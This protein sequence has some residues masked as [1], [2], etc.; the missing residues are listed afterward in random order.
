MI[1]MKQNLKKAYRQSHQPYTFSLFLLLTVWT[2]FSAVWSNRAYQDSWILEG[3]FVPLLLTVVC[4]IGV[5]LT[6]SSIQAV[7]VATMTLTF[8]FFAL[9]S[10]KYVTPYGSAIDV[11][12]HM[13]LVRHIVETGQ[14]DPSN[15]YQYTAG[16]H[17]LPAIL[18]KLSGLDPER[19]VKVVPPFLGSLV[20]AIYYLVLNRI[21]APS[22]L[23][24][25]IIVLSG[26][27]LPLLYSLNGTTFTTPLYIFFLFL[28]LLRHF[29]SPW[30]GRNTFALTILILLVG[31][32][33]IIWHPSSSL[34]VIFIMAVGGLVTRVL[35]SSNDKGEALWRIGLLI[36]VGT[37][38]YWIFKAD[39]VWEH[40]VK[41]LFL[42]L[43]PELTPDLVPKR[44][45]ELSLVEQVQIGLYS[46]ARDVLFIA[47]AAVGFL[48]QMRSRI[49]SSDFNR[50]ARVVA[51]F[52]L[53]GFL[54]VG[55]VFFVGFGSQGYRRFLNYIVILSPLLAGFSMWW[56]SLKLFSP[57]GPKAK[58]GMASVGVLLIIILLSGMQ[59]F[60]YQ[61]GVPTISTNEGIPTDT[62][63]LWMHQVNTA[64]QYQMLD[65][66]LYHLP[67]NV[68]LAADA[69]GQRQS[70]IFFDK[71]AQSRIRRLEIPLAGSVS[72]LHWPG[73]AGPYFEQAGS[74][75]TK[76]IAGWRSH[77]GVMTVYDNG[78]SFILFDP[79][80][81]IKVSSVESKQ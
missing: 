78:G 60:P 50:L 12:A 48:L 15:V 62:P 22:S 52:W 14:V 58:R 4:F 51:I 20:P 69:V 70:G 74:R 8:L 21:E 44:L 29:E 46:H 65:F 33:I 61:P 43:Q 68:S 24:K 55:V 76:A 66:A 75:S 16:F 73:I 45:F 28:F 47:L 54:M 1:T 27:N 34:G 11:S 57:Q 67:D 18:A 49:Q 13:S 10:L 3:L 56:C 59:L 35:G 77:P 37:F 81:V 63:V 17:V 42:S 32:T 6:S 41:N 30:T 2:L 5:V 40:F 25:I 79:L 9:P 39:L 7:T 80:G 36:F 19:Y 31:A 72:L 71:Q 38:T 23:K 26:L 64:Y 53:T